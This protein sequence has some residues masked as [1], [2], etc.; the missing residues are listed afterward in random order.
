MPLVTLKEILSEAVAKKY[1]VGAFDAAEHGFVEA[2]IKAAEEKE[3][4]VILMLTEGFL[5]LVDLDNFI[6]YVLDR[7]RRSPV[8]VALHLDHGTSFEVCVKAIHYGFS[9]VMIDGSTLPYAE[10]VAL[11]KKS[12]RLPICAG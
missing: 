5:G 3:V 8:P 2:I 11:V 9:S 6:P 1:A 7:I 10:N 12:W 4:P